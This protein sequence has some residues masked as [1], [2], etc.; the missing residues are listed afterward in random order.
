MNI[1]DSRDNA[2]AAIDELADAANSMQ[3]DMEKIYALCQEADE[4]NWLETI[5]QIQS[6]AGN[7]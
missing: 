4:D 1:G 6:L 7:Y 5:E 2:L 3:T